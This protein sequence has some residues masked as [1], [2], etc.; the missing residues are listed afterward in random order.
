MGA[1]CWWYSLH[2]QSQRC[3]APTFNCS[4]CVSMQ[5][6]R[7]LRNHHA[8]R[9]GMCIHCSKGQYKRHILAPGAYMGTDTCL[10]S[11]RR[12]AYSGLRPGL[13]LGHPP[14]P[15]RP[16]QVDAGTSL[17]HMFNLTFKKIRTRNT[18]LVADCQIALRPVL[19]HGMPMNI[20][21][22]LVKGQRCNI[23]PLDK[24]SLSN[25]GTNTCRASTLLLA[26]TESMEVGGRRIHAQ[27][28]YQ[29]T[30]RLQNNYRMTDKCLD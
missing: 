18:C 15:A 28:P 7:T 21:T 14:E 30:V 10:N 13:R 23:E 2:T 8:Y 1:L 12:W 25:S 20:D 27:R 24:L 22:V 4:L 3:F 26:F 6:L 9:N 5:C 11:P 29:T 16:M 17:L 19:L